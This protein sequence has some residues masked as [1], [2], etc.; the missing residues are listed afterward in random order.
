M[1][2]VDLTVVVRGRGL[3][4]KVRVLQGS[5]ILA[6]YPV[7]RDETNRQAHERILA[8]M[9][10]SPDFR[11]VTETNIPFDDTMAAL[12]LEEAESA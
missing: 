8:A 5:S 6:E 2:T 12:L 4:R 7:K 1:S 3:H 9:M 11:G 10:E